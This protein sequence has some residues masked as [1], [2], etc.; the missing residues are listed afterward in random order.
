MPRARF[1]VFPRDGRFGRQPETRAG[2]GRE[3]DA[4]HNA[5]VE[6]LESVRDRNPEAFQGA[7]GQGPAFG[8]TAG[9]LTGSRSEHSRQLRVASAGRLIRPRDD[10]LLLAEQVAWNAASSAMRRG[11]G[12]S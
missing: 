4:T 11:I 9:C 3:L 5:Q 12:R 8:K 1:S 10:L 7:L 2:Q 6:A